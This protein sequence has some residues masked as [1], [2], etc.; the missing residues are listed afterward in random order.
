VDEFFSLSDGTRIHYTAR[1]GKE[2][3]VFVLHGLFA[4]CSL[5]DGDFGSLENKIIAMDHPS[6]GLSGSNSINSVAFA[7][8]A[9]EQLLIREFGVESVEETYAIPKAVVANSFG[10]MVFI[11]YLCENPEDKSKGFII[12]SAHLAPSSEDLAPI[13]VGIMIQK[14]LGNDTTKMEEYLVSIVTWK[15]GH[16]LKR[17]INDISVYLGEDDSLFRKRTVDDMVDL[18]GG[19]YQGSVRCRY[20]PGEGHSLSPEARREILNDIRSDL[21]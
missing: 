1:E 12:S 11:Q 16:G 15:G 6:H 20:F 19:R 13:Y 8:E 14:L 17:S 18:L 10:G 7:T 5:A 21:N 9:Y 4:D 2:P 3:P